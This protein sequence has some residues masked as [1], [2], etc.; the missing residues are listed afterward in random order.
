MVSKRSALLLCCMLSVR[1]LAQLDPLDFGAAADGFTDDSAALAEALRAGDFIGLHG[2]TYMLRQSLELAAGKHLA[3]PGILVGD[4]QPGA[5][6]L[7]VSGAGAGLSTFAIRGANETASFTAIALRSADNVTIRELEFA[8]FSTEAVVDAQYA[9]GLRLSGCNFRGLVPESQAAVAI[10]LRGC[11]DGLVANNRISLSRPTAP[12]VGFSLLRAENSAF[13]SAIGN[14]M[15]GGSG[16]LAKES[17]GVSLMGAVWDGAGGAALELQSG[18]IS[19]VSGSVL[20]RIGAGAV[21]GNDG[22]V[23]CIPVPVPPPGAMAVLPGTLEGASADPEDSGRGL[24]QLTDGRIDRSAVVV[25]V[26]GEELS[27][28]FDLQEDRPLASL[29]LYSDASYRPA[30]Q[31]PS[32]LVVAARSHDPTGPFI[33]AGAAVLSCTRPSPDGMAAEPQAAATYSEGRRILLNSDI[34]GRY[35]RLQSPFCLDNAM[36][37]GE[38]QADAGPILHR[39]RPLEPNSVL[40]GYPA[41]LLDGSTE[42]CITLEGTTGEVVLDVGPAPVL[43]TELRLR[44]CFLAGAKLPRRVS[45]SGSSDPSQGFLEVAS[46]EYDHAFG[47]VRIEIP[48]GFPA[49]FWKVEWASLQSPAEIQTSLS[50]IELDYGA[51][52]SPTQPTEL[53]GAWLATKNVILDPGHPTGDHPRDGY[54]IAIGSNAGWGL[55][56]DL[57]VLDLQPGATMKIP[58]SNESYLPNLSTDN[59][60]STTL[61]SLEGA[62]ILEETWRSF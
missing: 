52:C 62:D 34:R 50:E 36:V 30:G 13:V 32:G 25:Q 4:P 45:V 19:R 12:P 56:S 40:D 33:T 9:N 22:P 1:A 42:N 16:V 54:G 38:I 57:V 28:V 21:L 35:L 3:G 6:L 14:L 2:R 27:V 46:G 10:L 23:Q 55:A 58:I 61:P 24:A 47:T 26:P 59:I 60:D 7:I 8:D 29:V 37:V 31:F 5:P 18:G 44:G 17:T 53:V 41:Q 51:A 48:E 11:R 39:L 20:S 49:R 15:V 43:P